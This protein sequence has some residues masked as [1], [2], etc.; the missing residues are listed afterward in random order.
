MADLEAIG[1]IS[2]SCP[3]CTN[4]TVCLHEPVTLQCPACRTP[5]EGI[6]YWWCENLKDKIH[7]KLL[8][9]FKKNAFELAESKKFWNKML[10]KV[11]K[12]FKGRGKSNKKS[13]G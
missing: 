7:P 8:E 2:M 11:K 13:R 4:A 5:N 12:L 9:A 6:C 1:H 3:Q 10:A